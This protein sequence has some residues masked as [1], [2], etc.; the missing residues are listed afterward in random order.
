MFFTYVRKVSNTV[1]LETFYPENMYFI[2]YSKDFLLLC[3]YSGVY[4]W[5][6]GKLYS[7]I[8]KDVLKL[9][10]FADGESIAKDVKKFDFGITLEE[11]LR[12]FQM[13][14][15]EALGTNLPIAPAKKT[16]EP[17]SQI[18]AVL[19]KVKEEE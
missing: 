5:H 7:P 8:L 18:D 16:K 1:R 10:D 4:Y 19:Q 13:F 14:V 12:C 3:I 11:S 6:E 2:H 9:E 17:W 15:A